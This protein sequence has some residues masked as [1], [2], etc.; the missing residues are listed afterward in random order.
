MGIV[1]DVDTHRAGA[2]HSRWPVVESSPPS[3]AGFAGSLGRSRT[4]P[5][6]A[7]PPGCGERPPLGAGRVEDPGA[8]R[9]DRSRPC[10]AGEEPT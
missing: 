1:S 3:G 10:R 7:V 5:H 6:E 8:D 4:G 2:G 9:S